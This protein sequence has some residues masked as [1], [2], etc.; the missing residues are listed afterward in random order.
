MASRK[1]G[2]MATIITSTAA[3][4]PIS[5]R[6]RKYTGRPKAPAAEKQTSCLLVRL[7]RIFV[8]TFVRS[9]GTG[10]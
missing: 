2:S 8:L 3:V 9:L 7:N 5:P 1:N 6:V 4:F 10:T